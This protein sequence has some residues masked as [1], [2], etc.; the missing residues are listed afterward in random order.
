[1][2]ITLKKLLKRANKNF[3]KETIDNLVIFYNT[4]TKKFFLVRGSILSP[5]L[6]NN[7]GHIARKCRIKFRD[8]RARQIKIIWKK[9][10][11]LAVTSL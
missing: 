10:M 2:Y 1:M 4:R 6:H 7:L 8:I 5:P 9:P 11:I 3:K